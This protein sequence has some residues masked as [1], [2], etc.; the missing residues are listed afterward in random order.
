MDQDTIEIEGY[1]YDGQVERVNND[2]NNESN[3]LVT[4]K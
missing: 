1:N 4:V 2:C 3:R